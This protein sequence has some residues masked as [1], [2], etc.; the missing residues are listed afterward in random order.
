MY[1]SWSFLGRKNLED[2]HIMPRAQIS[3]LTTV[4]VKLLSGSL[5]SEI[6]ILARL[7]QHDR[8]CPGSSAPEEHYPCSLPWCRCSRTFYRR[9]IRLQELVHSFSRPWVTRHKVSRRD[10]E[11]YFYCRKDRLIRP[12]A[13]EYLAH[14]PITDS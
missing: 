11:M 13:F 6:I 4:L 7:I 1:I 2:M 12:S 3:F 14:R 9:E 5:L 10:Q 8:L